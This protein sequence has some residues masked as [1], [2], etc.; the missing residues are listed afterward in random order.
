M[1][2]TAAAMGMFL[3]L[4]MFAG[5]AYAE[6]A[7][8]AAA[9]AAPAA[10]QAKV[11]E[12]KVTG[13]VGVGVFNR[14]IFRGYELGGKSVVVQPAATVSYRGFSAALWGNWDSSQ[15]ATQS[16]VPDDRKKN[17]NET[18]V[19]L[20]YTH[21]FG[22]L[23][24]TVGYIYYGTKYAAETQEIF[25]S[26][27][28][29]IISHPTITVNRDIDEYKGT[30]FNLSFSQSVPVYKIPTGDLTL[31]LGASF[32]FFVGEA[33][34]WKTYESS[35]GGYTGK[36]YSAPH[37]GMVKAGV[38]VPLGKGFSLQPVAQ[39]WFPLSGDA[40]RSV[41]GTS[42]NVNGKLDNTFVYGLNLSLAF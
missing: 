2:S 14:Y 35:T 19:T 40:S 22:K 38:T 42:Y 29:D 28:Y 3:A 4:G 13:N 7:K 37:D 41:N 24:L 32:G 34:Y 18:D 33:N 39:Y 27:T 1:R 9:A 17:F 5:G 36:K 23:G 15:H 10:E 26:A 12:P 25:G 20:S 31:D 30:Y 6:E 8:P 11:E 21:N 16:F